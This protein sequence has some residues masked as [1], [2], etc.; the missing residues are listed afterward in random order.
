MSLGWH[1]KKT[2]GW[3]KQKANSVRGGIKWVGLLV[4][5]VEG[6]R[7]PLEESRVIPYNVTRVVPYNVTNVSLLWYLT[8]SLLG[9]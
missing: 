6:N 7:S 9:C 3:L 4:T 1:C 2:L 8:V 5:M